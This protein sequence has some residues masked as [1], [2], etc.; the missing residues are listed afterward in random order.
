MPTVTISYR[1]LLARNTEDMAT[2]VSYHSA[3]DEKS[4]MT[5]HMRTMSAITVYN[6]PNSAIGTY[7]AMQLR[8][9]VG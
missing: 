5:L 3:G 6:M 9:W 2:R 8:L 4:E 1:S 7:D